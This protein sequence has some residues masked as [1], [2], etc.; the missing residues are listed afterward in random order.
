MKTRRRRFRHRSP[1]SP[2]PAG[3]YGT[4]PFLSLPTGLPHSHPAALTHG[5]LLAALCLTA[6]PLLL[7]G[8]AAILRTR[9][10]AQDHRV[11]ALHAHANGPRRGRIGA[12]ARDRQFG[13]VRARNAGHLRPVPG[14]PL[15]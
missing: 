12:P 5:V 13:A 14:K 11:L 15:R 7:F 10:R 1:F 6:W 4:L 3:L 9:G 8:I 2:P